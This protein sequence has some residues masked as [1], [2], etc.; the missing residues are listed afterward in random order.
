MKPTNTSILFKGLIIAGLLVNSACGNKKNKEE[1]NV[2]IK[3]EKVNSVVQ[4]PFKNVDVQF[5][6]FTVQPNSDVVIAAPS[7]SKIHIASESLRDTAGNPIN[8]P[9]EISYR[10][11]M[12]SA[13]IMA[14]GIPMMF[15][16][17]VAGIKKPFQS[18]GMFELLAETKSGQKV[19]INEDKPL[20]VELASNVNDDG[21]SNFY[22]NTT[23]GEW[24]Y[25]GEETKRE[26][27]FKID[28]NKQLKKLKDISGFLGKDFFVLDAANLLDQYFNDNYEKIA[29]YR[30]GDKKKLPEGL[31]KYGMKSKDV[32]SYSLVKINRLELPAGLVIWENTKHIEFPEWTKNKQAQFKQINGNNYEITISDGK[33]KPNVFITEIKAIMSIKNMF[34]YE[35]EMWAKNY[36]ENL[37]EIAKQ[38]DALATMNDVYRTLEVNAF[39]VYNCDRFYKNPESFTVKANFTFPK[40]ETNFKP[41]KIFYVSKK[42]KVTIP[43]KYD[44]IV[45]MTFSPD[46]T[47]EL[48]T[49]LENNV[50]ASVNADELNKLNKKTNM[51]SAVKLTFKPGNKIYSVADIKKSIGI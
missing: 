13:D 3:Q 28:L 42:D 9:V 29:P 26:N 39:G 17:P 11:F 43:Y 7:G 5:D 18:A 12:N 15:T 21:Y 19:L 27:Q 1:S 46:S 31:L 51:N 24:V 49:V 45:I 34:K 2:A 23:T 38:E 48:Y 14:S 16:D 22:L 37:S 50:L 30:Y 40:S 10:E 25:S 32:Y 4:S 20:K 41:E 44:E 47:A 6:K 8:E 35:P 33:K 36:E